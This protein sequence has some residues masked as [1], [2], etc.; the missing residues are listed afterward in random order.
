METNLRSIVIGFTAGV[1]V[2]SSIPVLGYN[3]TGTIRAVFKN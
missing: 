2:M 3:G 1:M